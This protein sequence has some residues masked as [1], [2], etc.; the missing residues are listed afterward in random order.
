M[1]HFYGVYGYIT[2]GKA[3][4]S[5]TTDRSW[6]ALQS[7]VRIVQYIVELDFASSFEIKVRSIGKTTV[8]FEFDDC[9]RQVPTV[10][11]DFAQRGICG[12]R[13]RK[14]RKESL[15]RAQSKCKIQVKQREEAY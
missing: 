5:N 15:N 4:Q 9:C 6:I 14:A 8:L 1:T 10:Q 3:S 13:Q 11:D 2:G 7:L 12:N